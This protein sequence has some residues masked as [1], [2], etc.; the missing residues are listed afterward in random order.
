MA[1]LDQ[2]NAVWLRVRA[3]PKPVVAALNGVTVGAGFELALLEDAAALA[4][5]VRALADEIA[6]GGPRAVALIKR[7]LNE[8][9]SLATSVVIE[10]EAATK[11][12]VSPD[13]QE[14]LR[15]F[16]EK[17]SPRWTGP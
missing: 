9:G 6:L 12:F 16:L 1:F 14:G 7:C 11:C 2:M 8:T 4:D 17:R 5:A 10:N 3:Y 15:A 13:Q